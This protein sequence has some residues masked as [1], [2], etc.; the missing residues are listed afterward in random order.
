MNILIWYKYKVNTGLQRPRHENQQVFT[1]TGL[2]NFPS[3]FMM[4]E[5]PRSSGLR[6]KVSS[7]S[8]SIGIFSS[9]NWMV[10]LF[11]MWKAGMT[12][13]KWQVGNTN[14]YCIVAEVQ[15]IENRARELPLDPKGRTAWHLGSLIK[16]KL[17]AR[18]IPKLRANRGTT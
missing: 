8:L 5:F 17:I 16:G 9:L 3:I 6:E 7:D 2:T 1:W 4:L 11:K 10:V 13:R 15:G 18:P 12:E 14:I